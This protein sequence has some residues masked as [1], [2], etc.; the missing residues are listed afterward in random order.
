MLSFAVNGIMVEHNSNRMS[1]YIVPI[2]EHKRLN[3]IRS[4]C[5]EGSIATFEKFKSLR[6][7]YHVIDSISIFS[8]GQQNIFHHVCVGL[9]SKRRS[10]TV[11]KAKVHS[12]KLF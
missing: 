4:H 12:T 1:Y 10:S 11:D 3:P 7:L 6:N 2:K 9:D 8:K 5:F